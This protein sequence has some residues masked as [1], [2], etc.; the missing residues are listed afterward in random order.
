MINDINKQIEKLFDS[1]SK[2]NKQQIQIEIYHLVN[3]SKFD[4]DSAVDL[5]IKN[6]ITKSINEYVI[7]S[8]DENKQKV[9]DNFKY[10]G[11]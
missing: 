8:N 4:N 3:S 5:H 9:L 1:K 10:L 2:D 11:N 7:N 6:A